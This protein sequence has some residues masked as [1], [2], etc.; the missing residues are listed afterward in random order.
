[1]TE[2][3][4]SA[5]PSHSSGLPFRSR[6]QQDPLPTSHRD[7]EAFIEQAV[8][9]GRTI[10]ETLANELRHG[11]FANDEE[12]NLRNILT[13]ADELRNYQSPVEFTIGLVGDS[14]VGT[15]LSFTWWQ[16]LIDLQAKVA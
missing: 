1:M 16:I 9:T 4:A 3:T 6:G 13:L 14:G 15:C 8:S 5:G 11:D 2:H 7:I 12:S 10:S